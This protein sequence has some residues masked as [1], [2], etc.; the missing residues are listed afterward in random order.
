MKGGSKN[1]RVSPPRNRS[2]QSNPPIKWQI[3]H[4]PSPPPR[5]LR[6]WILCSQHNNISTQIVSSSDDNT[7]M[8]RDAATGRCRHTLEGHTS[9]VYSVAFSPDGKQI[10]S[11][12]GDK[13]LK[14]WA[15]S[16]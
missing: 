12:S 6:F 5:L 1:L 15:D 3:P 16:L 8:Q 7:I 4:S 14:L 10:V 2:R 11:G 9:T 13:T